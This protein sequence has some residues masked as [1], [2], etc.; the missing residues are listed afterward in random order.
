[1]M[2]TNRRRLL[3]ALA[4]LAMLPGLVHAQA[5]P[6]R[7]IK[8]VLPF[9]AGSAT[10]GTARV[11]AEDLR[12]GLGQPIVIENQ[13]GADG[14]IAAMN[15]KRAAPDGYT[16]FMSTN[17]AHAVNKTLY[18]SLP[19]DPEKDFEP[20]AGLIRIPL[21]L[22][23]R[24]DFPATDVASFVRVAKERSATRPLSFGSGNTSSQIAAALLGSAAGM[25]ITPV[26]YRGTPQALT[27]MVG[28]QID[29]LLVDP[30]SSMGFVQS[31]Q[32]KVLA[33]TDNARH[34]L[35]PDVPTMPEAGYPAVQL[36]TWAALFA[37]A[38]TDPAIVE[39]L[40]REVA[41]SLARPETQAAVQKMAM[42]TM[43]MTPAELRVF[44]QAEIKRWGRL[45]ELAGMPKK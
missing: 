35:L 26:P 21:T 14:N 30:F 38:G 24:K 20:V 33:V 44:V 6:S 11:I 34:P 17:S 13:A 15:V 5:W 36:V 16:L 8:L 2:K 7:P 41:N 43:P 23:V 3:S 4:G 22:L 12:K 25:Q 31:G 9:P 37:P 18:A 28:G 39:R 32:L 10:D 29:A 1:M 40:S 19:F 27:D 45:V 42:T